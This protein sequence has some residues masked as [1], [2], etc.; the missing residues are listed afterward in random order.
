[1]VAREPSPLRDSDPR[2]VLRRRA[3]E[4]AA[5]PGADA[6]A[7]TINL[8]LVSVAGEQCGLPLPSIREVLTV[9]RLTPVPRTPPQIA[10]ILNV[11]GDILTVLD[12]AACLGRVTGSP[13]PESATTP[14]ET[15]RQVVLTEAPDG[16]VG[17]LVAEIGG[18]SPMDPQALTEPPTPHDPILG[19]LDA[20]ILVLDL[21][22]LLADPRLVVADQAREKDA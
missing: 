10:G 21:P 7:E 20:N 12:L 11:R 3:I 16:L 2:R 15:A 13:V 9:P 4:L 17:L 1:M 5:A 8:L 14:P 22:R 18:L 19:V 6:P